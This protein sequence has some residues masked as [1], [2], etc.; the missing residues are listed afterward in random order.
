MTTNDFYRH[1]KT[2][3]NFSIK[4]ELKQKFVI[5]HSIFL[6]FFEEIL[7]KCDKCVLIEFMNHEQFNDI[8]DD[9]NFISILSDVLPNGRT[10]ILYLL[11][12][13]KIQDR[14]LKWCDNNT[15]DDSRNELLRQFNTMNRTNKIKK[16]KCKIN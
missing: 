15:N 2:N 5:P 3:D 14:I 7:Q 12:L 10:N 8:L 4:E 11:S 1:L 9:S 6:L 16:L 13:Q